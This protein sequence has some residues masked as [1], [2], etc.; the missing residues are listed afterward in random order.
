MLTTIIIFLIVLAVLIF[1]HELGH[2]LAARAFGIR[3]DQ[4]KIG[5]G[6]K[7]LKWT[8]N[9]TEFGVNAIPFGGFVKI[10]G[11]N[12]DEDSISGADKDRSFVNKPR[13]QQALV[14]AA[15]VL[16]NFIFAWLLYAIVFMSG[17]TVSKES[18]PSYSGQ[19]YN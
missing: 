11:E 9:G 1:V 17:V 7:L 6:P 18:F 8:R 5:F 3:V 16:C 2:F 12:P 19:F 13:W 14:L 4:F 10:H 15:G